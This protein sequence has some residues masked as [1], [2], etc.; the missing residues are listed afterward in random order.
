MTA[1]IAK[2]LESTSVIAIETATSQKTSAVIIPFRAPEK[3]SEP[4]AVIDASEP[5]A[6][7]FA[8][9]DNM[10]EPAQ[11]IA[12]AF[13]ATALIERARLTRAVEIINNVVER[14]KSVP[15][16]SNIALVGHG[17]FLRI[18]GTDLDIEIA[19]S[20]PAAADR[21][22]G[23]TLPSQL[24]KDLLKKASSSDFVSITT[25]EDRDALDFER[26]VFGLQS[27]PIK[28]FPDLSFDTATKAFT[29]RGADFWTMIDGTID[30]V[31]TESSR[32]Y[33]NGIY[34]HVL[35]NSNRRNIVAVATDGHRLY[36]QE[37]EMPFGS[38]DMQS[39]IIP[40]KMATIL[41]KLLKGKACPEAVTIAVNESKIRVAFGDTVITSKT[42]DG[43]YPDYQRVIPA[44][45]S[46]PATINAAALIE[47]VETVSLISS[48]RGRAVKFEMSA[49][50][51]RLTVNNPEAG[52]ATMEVACEYYSDPMEVGFNATYL[53]SA[54]KDASLSCDT[55][56]VHLEDASSPMLMTSNREGWTAVV[57]PMRV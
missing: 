42:V 20:I 41:H 34:F 11:P 45:N 37:F 56:T 51:C 18:T 29:M 48:E 38:D 17:D 35:N 31:S 36:R 1:H 5:V 15:I 43:T 32:Y 47:G 10:P 27:L 8:E 54:I 33:L 30:A 50:A 22:F 7:I 14:R 28:D 53:I 6:Q 46:K 3:Q 40:S 52:S 19:I 26:S 16:L 49:G 9:N 12:P 24:L 13:G 55:V 39:V 21:E 4:E 57:M 44:N 25:G 23:T 2:I